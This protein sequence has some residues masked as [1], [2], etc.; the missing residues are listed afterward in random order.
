[1]AMPNPAE[2]PFDQ[3]LNLV[4]Q[5]SPVEVI[6]LRK[7]L[8]KK[9]WGDELEALFA[10]VDKRNKHL[11]PLSEEEIV[12]EMNAIREELRAERAQSSS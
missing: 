10:R 12:T 8:E 7:K 9:T 2:K 4:D 1:M 6:A 11:P 5:L 3:V